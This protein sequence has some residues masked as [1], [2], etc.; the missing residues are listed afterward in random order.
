MSLPIFTAAPASFERTPAAR[1]KLM[2]TISKRSIVVCAALLLVGCAAPKRVS[3]T[4]LQLQSFE[5][6]EFETRKSFVFSSFW[7]VFQARGYL[8]ASP[9]RKTGFITA[10]SPAGTRTN[11]WEAIS[12]IQT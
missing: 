10:T 3:E 5:A 8:A 11:F 4:P 9:A 2:N 1:E 7:R 6:R 12:G